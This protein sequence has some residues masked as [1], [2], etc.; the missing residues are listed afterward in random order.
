MDGE[1]DSSSVMDV[2]QTPRKRRLSLG[3]EFQERPRSRDSMNAGTL[4][5]LSTVG[6]GKQGYCRGLTFEPLHISTMC[7]GNVGQG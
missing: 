2:R 3:F 4:S 6:G 7:S 1:M 5:R